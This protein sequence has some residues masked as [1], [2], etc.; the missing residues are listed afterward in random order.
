MNHKDLLVP[1][2]KG[3]R[4]DDR[5]PGYTPGFKSKADAV[6]KLAAGIKRLAELQDVLYADRSHALLLVL[7]G[8]DS[9]GKDG[10]IK[11]V[12]SGVNPQGVDV[13]SFKTPTEQ[14]LDHDFLWRCE[15][16][17]PPRGRIA[18][19][20][21]SYYEEVVVVRVHPAFLENE[22]LP[23]KPKGSDLWTQRFEQIN[24]FERHL[25]ANGTQIVKCFLH[26][27]KAE[28]RRR[29]LDRID[30]PSK[31]W[32]L[33]SNDIK[34]RQFWSDYRRANEEMLGATSTDVAPWYVIPS[35][36]KWFAR[37]AIADILIARL[38]ALDLRYPAI[39]KD[40]QADILAAKDA[41]E[42]ER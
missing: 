31:N 8:M 40:R 12:M 23:A 17:L 1:S 24:A 25:V 14:E 3:F 13:F 21:R 32:K 11:H 15:R 34:E 26:I 6:E 29:L 27:S 4:L 28:Q 30:Q 18:I 41:L 38:E 10:A 35:D 19:F 37:V 20:N 22:R 9:A 16:V 5:D 2:G 33:S 36:H 7:Q 42:A 39:D